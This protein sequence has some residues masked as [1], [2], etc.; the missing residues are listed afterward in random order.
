MTYVPGNYFVG[1]QTAKI[2]SCL[3]LSL[4]PCSQQEKKLIFW[5]ENHKPHRRYWNPTFSVAENMSRG[6]QSNK[7]HIW[8]NPVYLFFFSVFK[9]NRCHVKSWKSESIWKLQCLSPWSST[10]LYFPDVSFTC[11]PE[12]TADSS[13]HLFRPTPV[14]RLWVKSPRLV[15]Y[16]MAFCFLRLPSE[17]K[18]AFYSL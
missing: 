1:L 7:Y 5:I 13:W 14:W 15:S 11:V 6:L 2:L 3:S 9:H 10:A 17:L 8:W 16:L 4:S 12:Q 18:G